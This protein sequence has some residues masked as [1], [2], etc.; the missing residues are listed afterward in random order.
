MFHLHVENHEPRVKVKGDRLNLQEWMYAN[1]IGVSKKCTA[2]KCR[3]FKR[4]N[5]K[6][7]FAFVSIKKM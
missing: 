5:F 6:V 7:N 2:Y 3:M 1:E 4:Q